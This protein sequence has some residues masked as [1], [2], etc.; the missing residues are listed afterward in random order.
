VNLQ[1]EHVFGENDSISKS[2]PSLIS[3]MINNEE[4]IEL[5]EGSQMRD[6]IYVSDVV[7][8]YLCVLKKQKHLKQYENFEVGI[9]EA[10]Q[11]KKF[12]TEIHGIINSKS[13]LKFGKLPIREN[14]IIESKARNS[15][16]KEIGWAPKFT[17]KGALI[18]MLKEVSV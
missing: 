16:L 9:G 7:D 13:N 4:S 14:E 6:F 18:H 2:I 5:S 10:I 8:A 15:N 11:F 3:R 17:L 1:L 12:I